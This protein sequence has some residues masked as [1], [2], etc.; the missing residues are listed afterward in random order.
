MKVWVRERRM[1]LFLVFENYFI[2]KYLYFSALFY[3][4]TR[5]EERSQIV[6]NSRVLLQN[7]FKLRK[8]SQKMN[9]HDS[10]SLVCNV[11]EIPSRCSSFRGTNSNIDLRSY[12]IF[13]SE[14]HEE[15]SANYAKYFIVIEIFVSS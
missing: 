4:G 6:E 8:G 14:A 12:Y 11:V 2:D 15:I 7:F 5:Q 1:K 13:R 3:D 9:S 10:D